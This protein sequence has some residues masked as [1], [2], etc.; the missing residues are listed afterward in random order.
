[1]TITAAHL[2]T[3]S[4]NNNLSFGGCITLSK[5]QNRQNRMKEAPIKSADLRANLAITIY[6]VSS[7]PHGRSEFA[8]RSM[9]IRLRS[10]LIM[11]KVRVLY[12]FQNALSSSYQIIYNVYALYIT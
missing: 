10:N 1:M 2:N 11:I 5:L 3:L 7:S 8:S 4:N 6:C 9:T 12:Q